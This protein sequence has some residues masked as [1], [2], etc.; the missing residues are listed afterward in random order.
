M[1]GPRPVGGPA[2]SLPD[3]GRL[4]EREAEAARECRRYHSARADGGAIA[5][6]RG[7]LADAAR[8]YYRTR[9]GC[10]PTDAEDA[11]LSTLGDPDA[12]AVEIAHDGQL[13]HLGVVRMVL[14]SDE[15]ARRDRRGV[16]LYLV[17]THYSPDMRPDN[18]H[19]G[20][21]LRGS[22]PEQ[23]KHPPKLRIG[24]ANI[25]KPFRWLPP[26]TTSDLSI[27]RE[28]L[29]NFVRHNVAHERKSG[30]T[31]SKTAVELMVSR[32]DRLFVLLER[33]SQ[34]TA[35]FGDWLVRV[36]RDLLL[37]LLEREG[38][39]VVLLPMAELNALVVQE[40]AE[41]AEHPAGIAGDRRPAATNQATPGDEAG[42]SQSE[43]G[44]F[45]ANCPA[46]GRR[47]RFPWF[48]GTQAGFRCG[49]CGHSEM[50]PGK[51]PWRFIMPDIVAYQASVFHLGVD[52]WV[53]GSRADYHPSIRSVFESVFGRK[54]PPTFFLTSVPV[55][56]GV[57]EPP[58]G[59]RKARL[60]RA[61]LELEPSAIADA[62]RAPWD[63]D[64]QIESEFVRGQRE[65]T[66]R[67]G[68]S[69]PASP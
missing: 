58:E 16:A 26:P 33:A 31:L 37:L 56:R 32:L 9:L 67:T 4:F 51:D 30:R 59:N 3:V 60:L 29:V 52:G 45:W 22:R 23:V 36:Q 13:P 55:F 41:I 38:A 54:A 46:C 62:L 15:I 17:G 27:L 21:P 10:S 66:P 50:L 20:M 47:R 35:D 18:I 19:F 2:L 5:E 44:P 48:P 63:E 42:S 53:A 39:G 57:G 49:A 25:H 61:L 11:S 69:R 14:K 8:R 1:G 65:T 7:S 34:E 40:L 68:Q 12:I 6:R 24:R 28:Q 64:P 43:S